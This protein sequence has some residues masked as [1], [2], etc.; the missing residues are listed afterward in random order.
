MA[1]AG[2]MFVQMAPAGWQAGRYFPLLVWPVGTSAHSPALAIVTSK[3]QGWT[4]TPAASGIQRCL[5]PG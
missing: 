2:R 3:P 1:A 4:W 5:H